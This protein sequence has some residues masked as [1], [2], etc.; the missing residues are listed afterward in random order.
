MF[1]CVAVLVSAVPAQANLPEPGARFVVHDHH[2]VRDGWHVEMP[3]GRDNRYPRQL[4]MHPERC[5]ETVRAS[6]VCTHDDGTIGSSKPFATSD[7]GARAWSLS[8]RFMDA[9]HVAGEF[10]IVEPGR[11]AGVR[12]FLA[13]RERRARVHHQ[14]AGYGT[15][16]GS[17]PDLA[18]ATARARAQARRL[19]RRSGRAAQR[20]FPTYRAARALGFERLTGRGW[21]RPVLFHIR[22]RGYA[23]DRRSFDARHPESLVYWWPAKGRPI[24]IAFMYRQPVGGWPRYAKPLLGWHTHG[25]HP[26][27]QMT[28]VWLTGA[29]RSAIA[30]CM[31][32]AALEAAIPRFR[33]VEPIRALQG[34]SRPCPSAT[35][36][37]AITADRTLEGGDNRSV[38]PSDAPTATSGRGATDTWT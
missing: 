26:G 15:P 35:A 25:T 13:R 8:T 22:H 27:N 29:L 33:Y 23:H 2:P 4:V 1:A 24:L 36:T 3:A 32:V 19:W 12:P 28:H 6:R 7:D 16:V 37:V 30:H 31:P 5:A 18:A 14:H 9:T 21:T 17:Y 11:D 20:R 34:P 38:R 10:H